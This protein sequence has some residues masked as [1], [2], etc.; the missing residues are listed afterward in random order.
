[1]STKK[2]KNSK[3]TEDW[4]PVRNIANGIPQGLYTIGIPYNKDY[5]VAIYELVGAYDTAG[6]SDAIISM[7]LCPSDVASNWHQLT[8]NGVWASGKYF[9]FSDSDSAT[10]AKISVNVFLISTR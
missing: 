8:G 10:T 9:K 5:L 1:M 7:F 2:K 3:Y 4:L 6:K